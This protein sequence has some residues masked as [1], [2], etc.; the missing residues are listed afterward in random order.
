MKNLSETNA[1]WVTNAVRNIVN[2]TG[3]T[4][5]KQNRTKVTRGKKL[6]VSGYKKAIITLKKGQ[7]IYLTTGI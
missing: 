7:S 1:T 6:K 4:L 2:Q 5:H 3:K